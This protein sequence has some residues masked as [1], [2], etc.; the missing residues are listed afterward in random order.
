MAAGPAKGPRK[1]SERNTVMGCGL[2]ASTP[3]QHTPRHDDATRPRERFRSSQ[4]NLQGLELS[5]TTS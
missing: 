5:M 1:L 2:T 4:G 3:A